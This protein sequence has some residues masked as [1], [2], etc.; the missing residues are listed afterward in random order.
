[1]PA[2]SI[3]LLSA[4]PTSGQAIAGSLKAAGHTVTAVVDPGDALPRVADHQLVIVDIVAGD[5]TAPDVCREIRTMPSVRAIPVLC[6]AQTAEVD[7]RIAHLE[8]G[9]DDVIT[10][11][12]E[13]RELEARVEAL[14][15]RF[16]RS[17]GQSPEAAAPEA[18]P[19]ARARRLI[20]VFSPK[21]GVGTTTIAT[22]I[23]ALRAQ[24]RPDR[25]LLMDMDLQFGQVA[26]HL[27]LEVKLSLA[28][29]VRDEAALR[30]PEL[31]RTYA[32]RHSTGLQVIAAPTTPDFAGGVQPRHVEQLLQTSLEAYETVVVD[33][34]SAL[35]DRTAVAFEL[36][37]RLILPVYPEIAALKAVHSLLDYLAQTSSVVDRTTFVLN[38]AFAR[39][40]LRLRDVESALGSRIGA[41]LPYDPFLYLKAVNEGV[42]LILGAPRS[43]AAE[44]LVRLADSV[45]GASVAASGAATARSPARKPGRL[46]RVLRRS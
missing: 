41:E 9:A 17:R 11:P 14:L 15:L 46:A 34:G 40:I 45:F 30:E 4:D 12:F 18:A 43:P 23:A 5:R 28:D 7:E 8:A 42:P 24:G 37:D 19:A 32:M 10:K 35:D 3:L 1:M 16:Q 38:N 6:V 13:A 44:R 31:L 36:A 20:V 2:S 22:N 26:T 27:N 21:G 33:A 25:V 39:D 29:L